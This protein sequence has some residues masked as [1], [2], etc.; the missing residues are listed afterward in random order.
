MTEAF[1]DFFLH[2]AI[3]INQVADHARFRIDGPAYGHLQLI[4]VPVAVRVIALAIGFAVPLV[5]HVAGVQAMRCREQIP[6]GQ[7]GLHASP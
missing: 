2:E 7:V 5:G 6:S 4:V 3:Q 1:D